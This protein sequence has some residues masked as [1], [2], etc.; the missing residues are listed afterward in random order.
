MSTDVSEEHAALIFLFVIQSSLLVLLDP[1]MDSACFYG[2]PV[3][4]QLPIDTAK[5]TRIPAPS[6]MAL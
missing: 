2:T 5:H 3:T 6:S 4:V 1:K